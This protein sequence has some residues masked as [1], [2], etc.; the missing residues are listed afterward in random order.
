MKYRLSGEIAYLLGIAIAIVLS[1][2]PDTSSNGGTVSS[3]SLDY[4]TSTVILVVL[5][6]VIGLVNFWVKDPIKLLT[7]TIGL[8]VAGQY[9]DAIASSYGYFGSNLVIMS[10]PIAFILCLKILIERARMGSD[11]V[12]T[13]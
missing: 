11:S 6:L 9:L 8:M 4:Y 13:A 1:F 10:A 7:V 12:D 5:G 2:F 3:F